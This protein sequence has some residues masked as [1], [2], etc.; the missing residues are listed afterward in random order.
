MVICP[1]RE[2]DTNNVHVFYLAGNVDVL[3]CEN[4]EC[5]KLDKSK[6]YF[7]DGDGEPVGICTTNGQVEPGLVKKIKESNF[8]Q[9]L[10]EEIKE[11]ER[12]QAVSDE[13]QRQKAEA[14]Q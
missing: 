12:Q 14:N 8:F 10:E 2:K 1:Y 9:K 5:D 4:T 3:Y 6:A 13:I 7:V 11:E